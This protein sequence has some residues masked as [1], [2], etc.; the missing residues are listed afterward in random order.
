MK[1]I[2]KEVIMIYQNLF[3]NIIIYDNF[4]SIKAY[5]LLEF[6]NIGM[7]ILKKFLNGKNMD[8]IGIENKRLFWLRTQRHMDT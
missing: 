4:E 1:L 2:Q 3:N 7:V 6:F 8:I 5:N